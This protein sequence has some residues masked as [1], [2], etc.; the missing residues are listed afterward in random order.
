MK[1]LRTRSKVRLD[2]KVQIHQLALV[3]T[4]GKLTSEAKILACLFILRCSWMIKFRIRVFGTLQL[5]QR[6]KVLGDALLL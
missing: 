4:K 5:L 2:D 3:I 1:E 6:R